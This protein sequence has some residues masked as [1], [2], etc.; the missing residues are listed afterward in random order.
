MVNPRVKHL[1][2][3][4]IAVLL[5]LLTRLFY[6]MIVKGPEFEE[7][8]RQN[9]VRTIPLPAPRGNIV[10]CTGKLIAGNS[11]RFLVYLLPG[12]QANPV[13]AGKSIAKAMGIGSRQTREILQRIA[14]NPVEGALIGEVKN[15]EKFFAL[16]PLQS[17]IPGLYFAVSPLRYYPHGELASHLLGFVGEIN[18][19][20]LKKMAPQGYKMGDII[21]K[22]GIEKQAETDLKGVPG[23]QLLKVEVDGKVKE[24]LGEESPRAGKTVFLY[25]NLD[26]Q[27]TAETELQNMLYRITRDRG[28]NGGAAAVAI[29]IRTGGVLALA[30]M[31]G[32]NPNSFAKGM[33]HK[34][35]DQLMKKE[36][37]MLN[38]AVSSAFPPGSTYKIITALGALK[39]KL[40][41]RYSTFYCPGYIEI[42]G[43]RINCF[44]RSGHGTIGFEKSVA[45]SCDVVFYILGRRLGID[46]LIY[47]SK[48]MGLG[49]K[50]GLDLPGEIA[51][52]LPDKNWREKEYGYP[53]Y[54]GDTVNT[55][56][57]QGFVAAT[58]LQVA[59]MTASLA[60]NGKVLKPKII[61]K[62]LDNRGAVLEESRPE[63]V[64]ILDFPRKIWKP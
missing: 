8:A 23:A 64:R 48:L 10:D 3:L 41:N 22:D 57:G 1:Q 21:G 51:G 61:A 52:N 26:L 29:D 55:S 60:N 4:L 56:I 27:K 31:P 33:S 5:I 16:T 34:E 2:F 18:A 35:Y 63:V 25:M 59:L 12:S 47:Y 45:Q 17:T 15:K 30:S 54:D 49:A 9:M 14:L 37:P 6:L 11:A 36:Y 32:F 38:R 42:G 7:K 24:I 28:A 43:T 62:I 44:V 39:E 58:P 20:E 50:T 40:I 53:W 46:R 13:L 19:E